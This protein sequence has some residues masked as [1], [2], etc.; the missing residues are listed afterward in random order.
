MRAYLRKLA[1]LCYVYFV[2]G[3]PFWFIALA[4]GL[5]AVCGGGK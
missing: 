1:R 4:L 2:I 5:V 3:W